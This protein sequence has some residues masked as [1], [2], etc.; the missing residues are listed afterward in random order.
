[1]GGAPSFCDPLPRMTIFAPD[2]SCICFCVAP[3]GPM[4]SPD[5]IIDNVQS[6]KEEEE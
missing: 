5:M 4:R 1:M 3:R 6:E 2:I